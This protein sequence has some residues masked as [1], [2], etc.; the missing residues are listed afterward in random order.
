MQERASRAEKRGKCAQGLARAQAMVRTGP[1]GAGH[2]WERRGEGLWLRAGC[3]VRGSTM[4]RLRVWL[5]LGAKQTASFFSQGIEGPGGS[6]A[7]PGPSG[8]SVQRQ[9][10]S[11][12]FPTETEE[13]PQLRLIKLMGHLLRVCAHI[14]G[15]CMNP[16]KRAVCVLVCIW[17]V[18]TCGCVKACGTLE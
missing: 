11:R 9:H 10:L 6:G 1:R 14:V 3:P 7:V 2:P 15:A 16:C 12:V 5:V 8:H 13:G 18:C 4:W 17:V